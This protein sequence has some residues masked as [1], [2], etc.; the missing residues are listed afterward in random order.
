MSRD[1]DDDA[2]DGNTRAKLSSS[3][4][5]DQNDQNDDDDA[6]WTGT[7]PHR[8]HRN[9]HHH[10]HHHHHV[11]YQYQQSRRRCVA[12]M[13]PPSLYLPLSD[14]GVV[15]CVSGA[16]SGAIA[17]IVV[18]PLDVLKTR[19]QVSLT[20][21]STYMSTLE[22]LRKIAR[23]EGARGL[24]RG[25][26][27]TMAALLPNWGVYFTTYGYLKYVFRERRRRKEER[28]SFAASGSRSRSR[29]RSR[30]SESER[31]NGGESTSETNDHHGNDTLAHIVSAGGAG[32]A[33][34]LATN[35]LWVAKTRLQ[36]QYSETLSS[37][38]VGHAR[39]PYKGT[40]DALRRI[41]RCEGIPGLYSGLGPSLL[42]ISHVAIQFP[43]YERLKHDL[44]H[45]R[46]LRAAD[47]LTA[48]DLALSSGVA[49]IVASTL[50]YPHEVLRSHMHVK[51]YGPFSGALSLASDIYR[52]GGAKAFYR[53]VGTNLLRTTPAAAITFTS[54][55]LISRELNGVAKIMAENNSNNS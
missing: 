52:E 47:E 38:L 12:E 26:G 50:T 17:A 13:L 20:S 44:A 46:N 40:L 51:G 19:L 34:I 43:I 42:G 4:L 24:Y 14:A 3:S 25:L 18:C 45:F 27:P 37:S 36:V 23:N 35:P 41:A 39:A 11:R 15:N 48:T 16:T 54:F 10:H 53:G 49:K 28:R 21:D 5:G 9:H 1:D 8:N 22:S 7:G 33:T 2:T 55:E 32:A 6:D 31:R 30:R 29:S